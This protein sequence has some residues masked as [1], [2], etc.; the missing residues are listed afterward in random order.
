MHLTPAC[1]AVEWS[2]QL[3]ETADKHNTRLYVRRGDTARPV[4]G[5]GPPLTCHL[6]SL[7]FHAGAGTNGVNCNHLTLL[8]SNRIAHLFV[9]S[10]VWISVRNAWLKAQVCK[11][12]QWIRHNLSCPF[13][14]HLTNLFF[15]KIPFFI[16]PIKDSVGPE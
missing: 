5:R 11:S 13:Q 1:V 8:N 12:P 16:P 4:T 6:D 14:T 15:C 9:C 10:S 2:R 3:W 7:H